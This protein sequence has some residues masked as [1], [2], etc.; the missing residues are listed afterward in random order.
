[1]WTPQAV[2]Y[3]QTSSQKSARNTHTAA[4]NPTHWLLLPLLCLA[5]HLSHQ[6]FELPPQY[7]VRVPI[8]HPTNDAISALGL[9]WHAIPAVANMELSIGGITYTAAPFNGW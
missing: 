2:A 3:A 6:L 5:M 9:Q 1:M 8:R 7:A 4:Y